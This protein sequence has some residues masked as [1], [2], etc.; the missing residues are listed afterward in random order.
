LNFPLKVFLQ[1][2]LYQWIAAMAAIHE[3]VASAAAQNFGLL[4]TLLQTRYATSEY[5]QSNNYIST[6]KKQIAADEK[7]VREVNHTLDIEYAQHKKYR[8]SHVKRLAY[9]IDGKKDKFE[10]DAT[11]EEKEWP[12]AVAV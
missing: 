7:K 10:A 1:R 2:A 3:R 4:N 9:K 11:K 6:S 5:Q 12:D 8:D